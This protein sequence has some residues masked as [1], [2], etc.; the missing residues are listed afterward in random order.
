MNGCAVAAWE[1]WLSGEN[2]LKKGCQIPAYIQ[3]HV[4]TYDKQEAMT[5][6][7]VEVKSTDENSNKSAVIW[8]KKIL[9]SWTRK[10]TYGDIIFCS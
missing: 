3:Y 2:K 6:G 5:E 9:I 4:R 1:Q 10:N 7:H 8:L